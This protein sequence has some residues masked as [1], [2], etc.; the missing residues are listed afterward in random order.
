MPPITV[1][2]AAQRADVALYTH[3]IAAGAIL[4]TLDGEI[5]VE[6]LTRGDRIITRDAGMALLSGVTFRRGLFHAVQIRGGS[7]GHSRP[8]RDIL[9]G[10]N[11]PIHIR[12]WRAQALFGAPSVTL[13]ASRLVDGEFVRNIGPHKMGVFELVFEEPHI[14]YADGLEIS[15]QAPL[16]D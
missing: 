11:T 4:L 3:G 14:F 7:L 6:H 10:T 1:E 15:T 12:D 2:N 13:P 9:V 5:P 8:D 16:L